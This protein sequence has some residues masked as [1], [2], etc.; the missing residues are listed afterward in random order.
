MKFDTLEELTKIF[1]RGIRDQDNSCDYTLDRLTLRK[2]TAL[3]KQIACSIEN[4]SLPSL[5]RKNDFRGLNPS[6]SVS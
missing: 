5:K 3:N 6:Y 2:H 4:F 1:E